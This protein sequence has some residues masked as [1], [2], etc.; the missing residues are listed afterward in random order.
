MTVQGLI[1]LL[2]A[3]HPGQQILIERGEW[4]PCVVRAAPRV[5]ICDMHN[6]D[7]MCWEVPYPECEPLEFE[8][9]E[10]VVIL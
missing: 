4:G 8:K 2:Q 6:G 9:R 7:D 5:T 1:E 3:F 10:K